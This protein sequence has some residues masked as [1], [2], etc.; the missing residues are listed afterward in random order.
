VEHDDGRPHDETQR[1]DDEHD[2]ERTSAHSAEYDITRT[3]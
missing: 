2:E 1:S 3:P